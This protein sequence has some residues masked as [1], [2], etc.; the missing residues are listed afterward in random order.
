MPRLHRTLLEATLWEIYERLSEAQLTGRGVGPI[1]DEA[2]ST[3]AA[4]LTAGPEHADALR[5]FLRGVDENLASAEAERERAAALVEVAGAD[6]RRF[7]AHV[8]NAMRAAGLERVRGVASLAFYFGQTKPRVEVTDSKLIPDEFARVIP[9]RRELR[10]REA[11][12][13]FAKGSFVPGVVVVSGE[14]TLGVR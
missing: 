13:E 5:N 2:K 3:I 6:R 12:Q 7:R 1:D 11:E 4:Y 10:V 14:P 8:L 9:E